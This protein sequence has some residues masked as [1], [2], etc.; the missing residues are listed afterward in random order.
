MTFK[1][2]VQKLLDLYN[3][4][5]PEK[6]F[7]RGLIF[8]SIAAL[9]LRILLALPA[10]SEPA[11]LLRPDSMGY[12]EPARAIASGDGLV[13]SPGSVQPEVV[14]P[15]G[16]SAFLALGMLFSGESLLFAALLG[17]IAGASAIIPVM[18]AARKLLTGRAAVCGGILYTLNITAIAASPLILSDTLLGVLTAWQFFFAIYFIKEKSLMHFAALTVLAIA[19]TL[20]K[21]VNLPITLIGLP[22]ILLLAKLPYRELLRGALLWAVL[23]MALLVPYWV[24]NAAICGDFDGNTANLYF[25]NGSAVMAHVTCESSEVWRDRLLAQAADEFASHPEKYPTIK[26]QNQWKKAQFRA[27]IKEYPAA[28]CITHLPNIFNLLPDV[29][30]L[31]ENN[32]A[33]STGRGTMAVLR[34]KGFFA[35]VDHYLN[36][37][38][39][40]LFYLLPL[41]IL[42]ALTMLLALIQLFLYLKKRDWQA[43]LLFGT[44]VFYYV[45]AP[46]P[47]ISPRYLLPALP[48]IIFM[49]VQC[50][51][52]FNSKS[53]FN[54]ISQEVRS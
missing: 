51:T 33:S 40:M 9:L 3:Q 15:V 23:L 27:M 44:L 42:Y 2:A 11:T 50:G 28:F 37:R 5:L 30:S 7:F 21:P 43:I 4:P 32:H 48:M 46:G 39:G 31:L 6:T 36:G 13:S 29:P 38:W 14:R 52:Y 12:W 22:L 1:S 18:L 25:H 24:R 8:C 53:T 19:G 49:A 54:N 41:L 45:W 35:A 17:C 16:Y 20:V 26:E 47:V 10:L 34:Q